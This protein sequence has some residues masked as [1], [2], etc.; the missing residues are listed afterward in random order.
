MLILPRTCDLALP[1]CWAEM[2]KPNSCLVDQR[3]GEVSLVDQR[4]WRHIPTGASLLTDRGRPCRTL[5]LQPQLLLLY[6]PGRPCWTFQVWQKLFA[7]A[8]YL[9]A[10]PNNSCLSFCMAWEHVYIYTESQFWD[11][12]GIFCPWFWFWAKMQDYFGDKA[13]DKARAG[14]FV[15]DGRR[16][17]LRPVPRPFDWNIQGILLRPITGRAQSFSLSLLENFVLQK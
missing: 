12:G 10:G 9:Q 5:L 17:C 8:N 16:G 14:K 7:R 3:L 11:A 4:K 15:G 13:R 6:W 1:Y 2:V